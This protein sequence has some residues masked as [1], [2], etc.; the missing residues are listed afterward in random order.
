M[1]W[2]AALGLK[3]APLASVGAGKKVAQ[4][5]VYSTFTIQRHLISRPTWQISQRC[6]G[7]LDGRDGVI[8]S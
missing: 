4:T 7:R 6:A 8:K 1:S 3:R 5:V 2:L